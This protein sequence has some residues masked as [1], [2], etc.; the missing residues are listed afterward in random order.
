MIAGHRSLEKVENSN[1]IRHVFTR[2]LVFTLTVL[3]AVQHWWVSTVQDSDSLGRA[4]W[5]AVVAAAVVR[6]AWATAVLAAAT[7]ANSTM[8]R[9]PASDWR[10]GGR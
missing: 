6:V 10:G 2:F 5:A 8:L 3:V 4:G 7:P 1:V 9:R